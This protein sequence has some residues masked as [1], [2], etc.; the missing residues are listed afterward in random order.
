MRYSNYNLYFLNE[1]GQE[2]IYNTLTNKHLLIDINDEKITEKLLQ[3]GMVTSL[4]PDEESA[5]CDAVYYKAVHNNTL[6][7]TIITTRQ[8][9]FA[10]KY[11]AQS[12]QNDV[13]QEEIYKNIE[14]YI[15]REI[16]TFTA[17]RITLFGGEPTLAI[18]HYEGFL[19]RV[20]SICKFY[21]KQYQ[22]AMITNGYLLDD[23]MISRLY[24]LHVWQYTITLDGPPNVHNAY[25]PLKNGAPSFWK[26]Y[27]NL[28][29]IAQRTDVPKLT[30]VI[31]INV[32][33]DTAK[34]ITQWKKIYD[35][36]L[37]NPRFFVEISIVENRGGNGIRGMEHS[38]VSKADT[39]YV[40]VV[41]NFNKYK[42]GLEEL[43]PNIFVCGYINSKS[44]T[45]DCKGELR[46]CSKLYANNQIGQLVK[47]G[48]VKNVVNDKLPLFA[49]KW[50]PR[51]RRCE[52]EPLCHGKRCGFSTTCIW[53]EALLAIEEH[54][55]KKGVTVCER[56][57]LEK[58]SMLPL[59]IV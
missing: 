10:C 40:E 20:R 56:L 24:Q 48:V 43:T 36:L 54:L 47:Y 41:K 30:V 34:N 17:L 53:E 49:V 39:E 12:K 26:I 23:E 57:R 33:K 46:A 22:V 25:R 11:C 1:K 15:L 44:L 29:S 37:T 27:K 35:V 55:R 9:N 13:M 19:K 51:C 4:S 8:C 59:E 52:V 28:Q 5:I 50:D 42:N 18:D 14:H 32:T 38:L 45:V 31:R 16:H 7:I 21:R 3:G 58:T 2:V 6:A